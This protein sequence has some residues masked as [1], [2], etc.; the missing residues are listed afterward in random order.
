MLFE[1]NLYPRFAIE[2]SCTIPFFF[3]LSF[4]EPNEN[5]RGGFFF[6]FFF[7]LARHIFPP[8]PSSCPS[9]DKGRYSFPR[10]TRAAVYPR[11]YG[12]PIKYVSGTFNTPG[13]H[14]HNLRGRGWGAKGRGRDGE[15][16]KKSAP[17]EIL[18][19]YKGPATVQL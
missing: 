17:P 1:N 6:Y 18:T 5:N 3:S 7:I 10:N 15:R 13:P 8:R 19:G 4:R 2:T 9:P 16:K 14:V 12:F 11:L